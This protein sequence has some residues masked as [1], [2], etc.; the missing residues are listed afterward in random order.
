MNFEDK[1]IDEISQ[2]LL[3]RIDE[4]YGE[5]IISGLVL[6]TEL[7][8][9]SGEQFKQLCEAVQVM[10]EELLALDQADVASFIQQNFADLSQQ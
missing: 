1:N 6:S 9:I 2:I 8:K 4:Q 7:G 3:N 5:E 10:Y